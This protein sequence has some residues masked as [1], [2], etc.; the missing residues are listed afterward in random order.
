MTGTLPGAAKRGGLQT[1]HT[2]VTLRTSAKSSSGAVAPMGGADV[3]VAR[4]T[5]AGQLDVRWTAP[6]VVDGEIVTHPPYRSPLDADEAGTFPTSLRGGVVTDPV[7]IEEIRR[8]IEHHQGAA[9]RQ[10]IWSVFGVALAL[11]MLALFMPA[12]PFSKLVAAIGA[13]LMVGSKVAAVL[14]ASKVQR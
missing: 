6:A 3:Q 13:V 11:V 9:A 12:W 5:D 7:V 8:S 4:L 2:P 1:V 14:V 10:V